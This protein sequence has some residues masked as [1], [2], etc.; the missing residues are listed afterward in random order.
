VRFVSAEPLLGPVDLTPWLPRLGWVIVGAES[1]PGASPMRLAWAR[2]L[3]ARCRAA[4]VAVF[5]KQLGKRPQSDD[6]RGTAIPLKLI[7][8]AGGDPGEW[9]EDLRVREWPVAV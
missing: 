1:G 9:P 6:G 3:V 7:D 8:R 4:G 2:S 5:V